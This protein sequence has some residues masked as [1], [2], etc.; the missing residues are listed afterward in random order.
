MSN[1]LGCPVKTVHSHNDQQLH[2]QIRPC[3]CVF[4]VTVCLNILDLPASSIPVLPA[5]QIASHPKPVEVPV[6]VPDALPFPN[7]VVPPISQHATMVTD[8]DEDE[9]LKHFEQVGQG[10][11][12]FFPF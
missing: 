10:V 7:S 11:L 8:A 4:C 9:G 5:Q 2:K 3:L 1:D 6:A 12:E